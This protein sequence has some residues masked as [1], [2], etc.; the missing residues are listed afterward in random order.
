MAVQEAMMDNT[1]ILFK[2][3][4]T[5]RAEIIAR[6][7]HAYQIMAIGAAAVTWLA[8]RRMDRFFFT[9]LPILVT[10]I[11]LLVWEARRDGKLLAARIR[12]LERQIN[13]K[14]GEPLLAW[15]LRWSTKARGFLTL[16]RSPG[17]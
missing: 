6:T 14:A 16:P 10:V 4:D 11:G 15:E 9:A 1:Q 8:S 7:G 13:E 12:E 17:K 3:Y 2:E 5:L